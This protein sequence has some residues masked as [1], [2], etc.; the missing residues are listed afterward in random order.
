VSTVSDIHSEAAA[1]RLL[2][3]SWETRSRGVSSRELVTE[4][5]AGGLFLLAAGGL[6]LLDGA[7]T[8]FDPV[9][10]AVLVA[11]YALVSRVEF[12]VGAGYVVPSQLVLV[13]MLVLLPP[14]TVPLLVA[15]GLLLARLSD[16]SRRRGSALRVLFSIADAWHAFGPAV[17][18]LLAGSPDP[19]L[20]EFPL[21]CVAL[22]SCFAFDA[23]SAMLREAA[24][25]GIAPHLQLQVL[26][27]VW[28]VDACLAPIGFLAAHAGADALAAVVLVLPLA[29]LLALL[30]RD[31]HA[32]IEQAQNRLQVAIRER[33]QA[34]S[35]PLTGLGNRRKLAERLGAWFAQPGLRP[36]RLLMLF[37]L[38]GFKTYNDTFGHPAGDALLAHV[39]AKL[40]AAVAP[41]GDAYRLGGDEFCAVLAIEEDR[42]EEVIATAA[43]ALTQSGEEFSII[44]SYG[45]VL[46]PHEAAGLEEALQLAD[47]RMYAHKHGR[48]DAREQARDVLMRTIQARQPQLGEHASELAQ[49]AAAVAR[50]LGVRGEEIDEIAR[51]AELHD[52]GKVGIPDAILHK[53]AA[54]DATEWELM[55][56]HTVLGERILSAAPALR[57]VG[58]LV[59]STHERWD[60]TGYPDRLRA[61]AIPRGAR[62]VAIC[63]AY[64]A[65]ISDRPYRPALG[66]DAAV[67]E[68]QAGA[69]TQFDPEAVAAF[70]AE[71]S[72]RGAPALARATV[73]DEPVA[74]AAERVRTLLATAPR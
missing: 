38:D 70:V 50:R 1:E 48:S 23:G 12:P 16:W 74:L 60:G 7:T 61:T 22:L 44:A 49:L 5:A 51:A 11:L 29:G 9:V 18:L 62:I 46:L 40:A 47:E 73:P 3:E 58:R 35:D 15:C 32:R 19:D 26:A 43:N 30:G 33:E 65:M 27:L 24:A 6:L 55:H 42:L 34:V 53:R 64:E 2:E 63:D 4:L 14:A 13:P 28:V 68:L 10:A 72:K 54:L 52:V 56:Q 71:V 39:G 37:D 31:R 20:G 66:H 69:G 41:Y 17:V 21:L 45:V 36:P 8:G 59:R 67:R 25:R 57:P